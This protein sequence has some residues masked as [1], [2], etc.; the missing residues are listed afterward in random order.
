[1]APGALSIVLIASVGL[2]VVDNWDST[3]DC[4]DKNC[5]KGSSESWLFSVIQEL[6]VKLE[7][8]LKILY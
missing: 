2:D 3:E 7:K 4:D 1:L 8:T 5:S 6:T